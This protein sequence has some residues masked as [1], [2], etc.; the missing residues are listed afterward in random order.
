MNCLSAPE[1][2]RTPGLQ[3]R[4]LSLY[5]AELRAQESCLFFNV[6]K[7]SKRFKWF[8]KRV[9]TQLIQLTVTSVPSGFVVTGSLIF[10]NIGR[11]SRRSENTIVYCTIQIL[12]YSRGLH[13]TVSL[14]RK[15]NSN[16]LRAL[17]I[18]LRCLQRLPE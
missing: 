16:L 3:L 7:F 18:L 4:R 9:V 2:I 13:K 12:R 5:P 1:A 10:N 14:P 11:D 15:E 6:E 17:R 8:S